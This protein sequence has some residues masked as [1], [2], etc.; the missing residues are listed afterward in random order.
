MN[1]VCVLEFGVPNVS[2]IWCIAIYK[3][4]IYIFQNMDLQILQQRESLM[5]SWPKRKNQHF[6]HSV[7]V[8]VI[9][10]CPLAQA[11]I[12]LC[13]PGHLQASHGWLYSLAVQE[14]IVCKSSCITCPIRAFAGRRSSTTS[15]GSS[16]ASSL[17][18][19]TY[20]MN[21]WH[22][23]FLACC[24]SGGQPV[25]KDI[26]KSNDRS[27]GANRP[28]DLDLCD[29]NALGIPVPW[30]SM[31]SW[32]WDAVHANLWCTDCSLLDPL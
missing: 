16:Q 20:R 27:I 6:C 3:L 4:Y 32:A 24:L 17:G 14:G 15:G 22:Q 25:R 11:K 23:K 12:C 29:E 28:V 13:M 19:S 30:K 7:A 10:F 8:Q 21:P 2:H 5:K 18:G 1:A 26:A 9:V 31:N